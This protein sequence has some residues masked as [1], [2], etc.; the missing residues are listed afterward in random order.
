MKTLSN[1]LI[2]CLSL[3]CLILLWIFSFLLR[4]VYESLV[5]DGTIVPQPEQPPPTVPMDY[6]WARVSDST[7]DFFSSSSS[8]SNWVQLIF[9][10]LFFNVINTFQQINS[11]TFI[12]CMI[13]NEWEKCL[14]LSK[15]VIIFQYLLILWSNHMMLLLTTTWK[16][17]LTILLLF[18]LDDFH[19]V[20]YIET[21][22]VLV[23]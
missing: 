21:S 16:K 7:S 6:A 5:V 20:L 17:I 10:F 19:P 11:S 14:E 15:S 9:Y 8:S 23:Y 13:H 3:S 18:V 12:T 4:Q 1:V 2:S 22:N